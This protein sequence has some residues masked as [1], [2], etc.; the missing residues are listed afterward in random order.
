[1]DDMAPFALLGF[2]M[3][4]GA[5]P[6]AT[7]AS[8]AT[9]SLG[10]KSI[11]GV[12]ATGT[13]LVRNIPIGVLGNEKP[14]T[15]TLDRWVSPDLGIAVQIN[16]KSSIGG[17]VTLNLGQV[18]RTEP[19]RPQPRLDRDAGKGMSVT[20]GFPDGSQ[21]LLTGVAPLGTPIDFPSVTGT[22]VCTSKEGVVLDSDKFG[23]SRFLR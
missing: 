15:S 1:M 22:Y 18:V 13:R 8:S 10:Q 7:E 6:A 16:Q 23:I 20:V 2:G 12:T 21:C 17:E 9:S 4:I 5:N 19:D 11:N 14:I 3:G